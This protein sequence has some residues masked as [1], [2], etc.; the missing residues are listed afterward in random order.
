MTAVFALRNIWALPPNTQNR[1]NKHALLD[2]QTAH[3]FI[4]IPEKRG[5]TIFSKSIS[6]FSS[7]LPPNLYQSV[8]S[9]ISASEYPFA[10]PKEYAFSESLKLNIAAR[11]SL[12]LFRYIA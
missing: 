2:D 1:Y 4:K 9:S 11:V 8:L 12:P 6:V 5:K 7:E 3:V 10:A